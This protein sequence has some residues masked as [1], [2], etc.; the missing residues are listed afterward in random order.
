MDPKEARARVKVQ[1]SMANFL[2]VSIPGISGPEALLVK[3]TGY[4]SKEFSMP[5][6]TGLESP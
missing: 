4:L 1:D 3:G 6:L 2:F 5:A